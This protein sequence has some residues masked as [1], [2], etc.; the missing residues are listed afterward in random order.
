M[1]HNPV[2]VTICRLEGA[3]GFGW[4]VCGG[5]YGHNPIH[6]RTAAGLFLL[7]IAAALFGIYQF[8]S[9]G[10]HPRIR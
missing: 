2:G 6:R 3:P 4:A 10:F 9:L 5:K 8:V 7:G 1:F